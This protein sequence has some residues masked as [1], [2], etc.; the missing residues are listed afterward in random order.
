MTSAEV[1][2]RWGLDYIEDSYGSPCSAWSFK[3]AN[4][5]Y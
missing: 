2:I 1:Q 3:Q 5:W 4:N